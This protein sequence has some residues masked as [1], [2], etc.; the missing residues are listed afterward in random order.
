MDKEIL[1]KA[2]SL[3]ELTNGNICNHCLGR[4]FSDVVEG[5][6]NVE[7]FQNMMKILNATSAATFSRK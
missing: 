7:N 2:S 6:G 5:N 1:A 3:I 4:K